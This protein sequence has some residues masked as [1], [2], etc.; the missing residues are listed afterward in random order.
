[1]IKNIYPKKTPEK[2]GWGVVA[3]TGEGIGKEKS[4]I[5]R[6]CQRESSL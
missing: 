5:K 6:L 4:E 1:M 2:M 3:G